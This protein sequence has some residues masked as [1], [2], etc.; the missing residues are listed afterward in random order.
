MDTQ[1]P[2][3]AALFRRLAPFTLAAALAFVLIACTV[4]VHAGTFA[5]ALALTALVVATTVWLPWS[6]L[7]GAVRVG[8][9]L[10]FFVA[11]AFLREA[12][13]G[14]SS[15]VGVLVLLPV[16]WM[17]LHGTRTPLLVVLAGVAGFY[18]APVLIVGG[19]AYPTAGLRAGVLFVVVS[20][21]IGYT[22]QQ[23]V[24]HIR[25]QA[26]QLERHASDLRRVAQM[27]RRLSVSPDPRTEVCSAA[28][29]LS[30]AS[31][32]FLMEPRGSEGLAP[33][34]MVGVDA[35][36]VVS[37]DDETQRRTLVAFATARRVFNPN[38]LAMLFEPVVQDGRVVGVLVMG[39][40]DPVPGERRAE[41]VTLLAA[42]AALAI[43][44]ADLVQELKGLA[45]CD[46]LTG[47]PNRRAWDATLARALD[48]HGKH[49]VCVALLDLDNFKA[50]NDTRGHQAGDRLLKEAAAAWR[51]V[52]RPDDVLARYGGEEFALVLPRC[53]PD[54]AAAVLDRL[55]AATPG[56]QTCSAGLAMWDG[57]ETEHELLGRADRALYEAKAAG[58]DCAIVA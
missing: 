12:A 50:F 37:G 26:E 41:F 39:W 32:A 18:F 30:G 1:V 11:V 6:R 58:R 7:P 45:S 47:L 24:R 23:L 33:T 57:V 49:P 42:E 8:P 10:V 28:C 48:D 56:G 29:E 34:A 13:G 4:R 52:L 40:G 5:F 3:P 27:G 51:N 43:E 20:A 55:R 17:A 36:R 53:A 15:G 25:S 16:F 46:E 9:S 54:A 44:Q 31:F 2:G 38:V 35:Q 19:T 14:A 21:I 22:V